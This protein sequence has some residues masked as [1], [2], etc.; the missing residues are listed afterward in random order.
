MCEF[1][2]N[3]YAERVRN[4]VKIGDLIRIDEMKGEPQYMFKTGI[5]ESIDD[6]GQIHGTWGGCAIIPQDDLF[7]ILKRGNE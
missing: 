5:V 1:R 7:T 3:D 2:N 4:Y 6:L